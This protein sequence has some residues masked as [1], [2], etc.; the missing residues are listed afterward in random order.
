[1]LRN[2]RHRKIDSIASELGYR[3]LGAFSKFFHHQDGISPME[4]RKKLATEQ[5]RGDVQF[6]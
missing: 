6:G 3:S 4:F 2:E 5:P 1:M